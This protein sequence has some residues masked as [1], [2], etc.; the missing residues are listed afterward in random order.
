MGAN[1]ALI[2]GMAVSIRTTERLTK[3]I[4]FVI[5]VTDD[6]EAEEFVMSLS[7]SGY[8]VDT[9][10]QQEA[11]DRFSAVRLLSRGESEM[12]FDLLFASSG[13]ERE[14][15]ATAEKAEIFPGMV[16]PVATIPSLIALKVLSANMGNRLQD[17]IDLQNLIKA[18]S[19]ADINDA[20]ALLDLITQRGYNRD[21][22][23][24]SDL[25]KYQR[26]ASG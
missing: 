1:F 12:F 22:D 3:D 17:I 8:Y 25:E 10:L 7:R 26:M 23:L 14:V 19:Q 11:V 16:G 4:D 18:A 21:K 20:R 9:V 24:L 6:R 15:V 13:I 2:G 5:A